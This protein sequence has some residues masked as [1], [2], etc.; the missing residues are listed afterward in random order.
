M[1]SKC[2]SK[3]FDDYKGFDSI[4]FAS[5]LIKYNLTKQSYWVNKSKTNNPLFVVGNSKRGKQNPVFYVLK[6]DL[7][8]SCDTLPI[9]LKFQKFVESKKP[10]FNQKSE[11]IKKEFYHEVYG[12]SFQVTYPLK[13][14]FT[15]GTILHSKFHITN[16]NSGYVLHYVADEDFFYEFLPEV[17]AMVQSFRIMD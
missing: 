15:N 6:H 16:K 17:K 2:V 13:N 14:N 10:M 12:D 8:M 7:Q 9:G 1:Y 5:K 11:P 3:S 4:Q